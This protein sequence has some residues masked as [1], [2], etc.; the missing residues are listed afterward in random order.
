MQCTLS[1]FVDDTKLSSAVESL[2]VGD[3]IQRD[4]DKLG[5]R[6]HE[7]HVTFNKSKCKVLTWAGATPAISTGWGMKGLRAAWLRRT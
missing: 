1:K 5:D 4:L 2:D 6:A 7:N 3:A